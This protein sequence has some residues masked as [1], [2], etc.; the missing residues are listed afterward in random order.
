MGLR[1]RQGKDKKRR[2]G[3]YGK[4]KI[5]QNKNFKRFDPNPKINDPE[6]KKLWDPSKSPSANLASMGLLAKPNDFLKTTLPTGVIEL[7]DIPESDDLDK[8]KRIMPLSEEDQ[9]YIAK[10]MAKHGDN[11][12]KMFMDIKVNDMQHTAVQLKKLGSRFLLLD[13]AERAVEVPNKVAHLA[14]GSSQ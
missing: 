5:K 11:Y 4:T 2:A 10:C 6:V 14:I 8:P 7:F 9:S 1:N 3:R 13:E 12:S